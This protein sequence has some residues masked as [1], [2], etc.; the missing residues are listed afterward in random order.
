LR[1]VTRVYSGATPVHALG[2]LD[3]DLA[4]GEFFSV[5]GPS[6][7]GKS[8]LLDVLA[9][10]NRRPSAASLSKASRL[11]ARSRTASAWCSRKIQ[12]SPG[13]QFATMLPLG[14][15]MPAWNSA[16]IMGSMSELGLGRFKTL[17][18]DGRWRGELPFPR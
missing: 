3:L 11:W 14:C 8:T 15:V 4:H 6:G 16:T 7:F 9:G 10:L 2:P 17:Y 13:S 5:V 12:V 1:G 18:P